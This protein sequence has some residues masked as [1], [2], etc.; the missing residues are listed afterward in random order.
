M[1]KP[2]PKRF[3][4]YEIVLVNHPELAPNSRGCVLGLSEDEKGVYGY[5]IWVDD[6]E[7]VWMFD[8]ENLQSTG[9]FAKREDF[10][11]GATLH[12]SQDG[13]VVGYS[14]G[15]PSEEETEEND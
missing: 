8:E 7:E 1:C 5:A 10:Y 15:D 4:H 2:R 6:E 9:T 3:D 13:G 11:D 12:V 14:W